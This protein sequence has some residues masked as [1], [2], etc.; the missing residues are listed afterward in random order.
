MKKNY[1]MSRNLTSRYNQY[2]SEEIDKRKY[3]N[4][5]RGEIFEKTKGSK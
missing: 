1:G 3:Q 4:G 5:S 2:L